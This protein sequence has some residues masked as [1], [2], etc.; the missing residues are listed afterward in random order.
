M[1]N[2]VLKKINAQQK[3]L[4]Q[5]SPA[6]CVGEQ[7]KAIAQSSTKCA[8]L[9][10]QDLD[11][12]QG[13][14]KEVAKKLQ[15]YADK[16]HKGPGAFCITPQVADS[17]IRKHYGLPEIEIVPIEEPVPSRPQQRRKVNLAD[18]L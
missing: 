9:L 2:E 10:L 16:N 12:P 7:L 15:E 3:G 14:I 18:F 4:K 11:Q 5:D 17:I 8:E 6:F 13:N 1:L